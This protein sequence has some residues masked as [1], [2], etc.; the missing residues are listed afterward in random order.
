MR[1]ASVVMSKGRQRGTPR[2]PLYGWL[3][4][5]LILVFWALN[6]SLDGLRTHWGFFPLWLGYC[7]AVDAVVRYRKG[8][9]LLTRNARAY[10][11]LFLLSVPAWW[12]FEFINGY[13]QN[14]HYQGREDFTGLQFF[15]FSSL[16]FST[17]MPAVF[18]T[19]E[20]VGTFRWTAALERGPRIG[21]RPALSMG[22]FC[23]GL[24]MF[25]SLIAWPRYCFPLVWVSVLCILDPINLWLRHRSLF[26]YVAEGNWK[27]VMSLSIGCLICGF[28]WE[29]WNFY[30]YPRWIYEVPFVDFLHIFEMPL[31]GYGGYLPFSLELLAIYNFVTGLLRIDRADA[32]IRF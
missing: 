15:L 27:P 8:T 20:L 13:T 24:L 23:A 2:F 28:F 6:W 26:R 10:M 3:G 9:S 16:S 14:W 21:A 11:A 12:L 1:R 25:W 19:A 4:G 30:S 7:L 22:I 5:M 31:L 17:V 18:G 29:L 32:F